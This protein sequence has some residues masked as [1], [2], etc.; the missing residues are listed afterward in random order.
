MRLH[1]HI[2]IN[3]DFFVGGWEESV[4][5]L[6]STVY[7]WLKQLCIGEERASRRAFIVFFLICV[8]VS[9]F[10]TVPRVSLGSVNVE[11]PGHTLFEWIKIFVCLM[12]IND[13][14]DIW[15]NQ[16][17]FA[18]GGPTLTKKNFKRGEDQTNT[19]ISGPSSARQRNAI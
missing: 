13:L 18:R 16:E 14:F 6:C 5:K 17:S 8:C 3:Q 12:G 4:E 10:L 19:T 1:Y 9:L 15:G 2:P 11:F 7:M